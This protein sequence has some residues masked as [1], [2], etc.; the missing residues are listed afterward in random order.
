MRIRRT[1][2]VLVG[3]AGVTVVGGTTGPVAP[4]GA[5]SSLGFANIIGN[6]V[7]DSRAELFHYEAGAGPDALVS[8]HFTGPDPAGSPCDDWENNEYPQT[9]NGTY[10]PLVGDFDGDNLDEIFWYAPGT[11]QDSMWHFRTPTT[12]ASVPYT[13]N[14]TFKPFVGDFTGDGAD[15]IFWYA[16]GPAADSIW[17]FN[18]GGSYRSASV[19]VGGNYIPTVASIGSNNTDD[20]FWYGPGSAPDTL[21]DFNVGNLGHSTKSIPVGGTAYQPFSGDFLGDGWRG[22]DIF[23]YQPNAAQNPVW[24]YFQGARESFYTQDNGPITGGPHDTAVGDLFGD[25]QDDVFWLGE[26]DAELWN[27]FFDPFAVEFV[28]CIYPLTPEAAASGPAGASIESLDGGGH[29]GTVG[30]VVKRTS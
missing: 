25:G 12:H 10:L 11:A 5:S 22:G 29:H 4:A 17:E 23:W 18:Q 21:W 3:A 7:G 9:I 28:K 13:V 1:V 6:F 2:A 8:F 20:L 30:E 27:W 24:Q 14:G 16:P 15:D 19:P 26:T